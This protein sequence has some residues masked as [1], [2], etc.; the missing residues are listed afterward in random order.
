MKKFFLLVLCV[1]LSM[2][3]DAQFQQPAYQILGNDTTCQ[4]FVYSPGETAGLHV[5]YLTDTQSW[6]DAGKV[7]GSDYA[8]WGAEKRCTT[9]MCCMLQTE[10]GG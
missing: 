4:I 2:S 5:A 6:C 9:P 3:V 1:T 8:Q 7:C 10:H